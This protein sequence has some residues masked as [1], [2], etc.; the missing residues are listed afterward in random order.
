MDP[1]VEFAVM[2][3]RVGFSRVRERLTNPRPTTLRDVPQGPAHV[4]KEWLTLALCDGVPG[5]RVT[6]FEFGNRD[7]GATSRCPLV[8]T[9]ND[10]GRTAGLPDQLFTKSLPTFATRL[11]SAA[12]N[13][14][15]V[16][17]TFYTQ[18][19]PELSIEAPQARYAA[20]DPHSERF[21]L[22]V[23]DV[24]KARGAT[25]GTA[26]D[27]TLTRGQADDLV[28]LLAELHV[29]FWQRPLMSRFGHWLRNSV[30]YVERLNVTLPAR[31]RI[32]VGC[33]RARSVLSTEFFERR[34]EIHPALMR[35][36]ARNVEGP[37]TLL[38][39]DVHPGNWYVTAEGRM[40]LYDW[41]CLTT[42]GWARD[43]AYALATHLP[44]EDRR[45]WERKLLARY[46]G[47][48][49][50]AGIETPTDDEAFLLYG[51]QM[52]HPLLMWLGTLGLSKLMPST[53]RADVTLE[54]VRRAAIAAQDL[55]TLDTV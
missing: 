18:L 10:V 25:F 54:T 29:T 30:E 9:Y 14:S 32:A 40:G 36:M 44:P 34:H 5:A 50:K 2:T 53:Q 27:R 12:V 13:L 28:D 23:E 45:A 43:V 55:R 48:L 17:A 6:N 22:I 51:Q 3:G 11:L 42:G 20:Y 35:A 4:T 21:F 8:V 41:S 1:R 39:T 19:R 49:Q 24:A 7:D 46:L 26:L 33:E 31:K 37:Q 16:E 52:M 15:E 47:R 38:H